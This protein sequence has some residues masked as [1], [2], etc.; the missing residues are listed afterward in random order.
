MNDPSNPAAT[1]G[2][3][4]A[5]V[6]PVVSSEMVKPMLQ[7]RFSTFVSRTHS[8]LQLM[9][10]SAVLSARAV[11]A[12]PSTNG[13]G[14]A[15]PFQSA[16]ILS[17][18][19]QVNL[20][21]GNLHV[22]VLT[23][24]FARGERTPQ[25]RL[26]LFHNSLAVQSV[27]DR[28][29]LGLG[30]GWSSSLG[31]CVDSATSSGAIVYLADG[32]ER[33]LTQQSTGHW[34]SEIG[35]ELEL[36]SSPSGWTLR[37]SQQWTWTYDA[38]GLVAQIR[39]AN[40]NVYAVQRQSG[41]ITAATDPCGQTLTFQSGAPGHVT[42]V[43]SPLGGAWSFAYD[44]QARVQSI[45]DPS[46]G[47]VSFSYDSKGRIASLTDSVGSLW[48][49][50]YFDAAPKL[51][52]V[53]SVI[54]P[55]GNKLWFD[56]TWGTNLETKVTDT[57]GAIWL[58]DHDLVD[59]PALVH[60]VDPLGHAWTYTA[61]AS[62]HI[63]TAHSP[64][65]RTW[66][67]SYDSNGNRLTS[68]DPI[69]HTGT[70]TYDALNNVT[71]IAYG[72][73]TAT[74]NYADA[75]HPTSP[76][77][78]VQPLSTGVSATTT[79][80]WFGANDGSPAGIWNGCLAS[81][82]DGAGAHTSF[83]YDST[84]AY[85]AIHEGPSAAAGR[86]ERRWDLPGHPHFIDHGVMP[87]APGAPTLPA[88]PT[89]IGGRL[90]VSC[91]GALTWF[92]AAATESWQFTVPLGTTAASTLTRSF[93]YDAFGRPTSYSVSTDEA[94][95]HATPPI[96]AAPVV[97]FTASNDDVGSAR[98]I[99]CHVPG[100]PD[101]TLNHAADACVAEWFVGSVG[102]PLVHD[103][104]T[105]DADGRVTRVARKDGTSTN[106]TYLD[107][108]RIDHIEHM[109]GTQSLLLLDYDYD[110]RDL[111]ITL[112]ETSSS[113]TVVT[114]W[115]YDFAARLLRE[116]RSVGGTVVTEQRFTYD[117]AGNRRSRSNYTGAQLDSV[118]TYHYDYDN[119]AVHGTHNNRVV[120]VERRASNRTL[121]TTLYVYY[122][123][124]FGHVSRLARTTAGST[125]ISSTA[126]QYADDGSPW[127][128]WD[129]TWTDTGTG[130]ANLVRSHALETR[131]VDGVGRI[132]RSLDPQTFA[133]QGETEWRFDLGPLSAEFHI[134][135]ADGTLTYVGL[136]MSGE[137]VDANGAV[138]DAMADLVGSTR[139]Y[140]SPS[141]TLAQVF[142][143][144]GERISAPT[145]LPDGGYCGTLGVRQAL[146]GNAFTSFGLVLA[147]H[148]WYSP[149]LGRFV[150][151]DP[152][153]EHGGL[154]VYG[155]TDGAPTQSVDPI[156][157]SPHGGTYR[158]PEPPYEGGWDDPMIPRLPPIKHRIPSFD[159]PEPQGPPPAIS[160][161]P[162]G[163]PLPP[164]LTG[165]TSQTPQEDV[166]GPPAPPRAARPGDPGFIGPL[167]VP[168]A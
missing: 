94:F 119:L 18:N 128:I 37:D 111:P 46:Y 153:G 68:T 74:I 159:R 164:W 39:D 32:T 61:D 25:H 38:S 20:A 110:S 140:F 9:V 85:V 34:R 148:R 136:D 160:P 66:T 45:A 129:E 36:S 120:S 146:D 73:Q 84:A 86:V 106:W 62:R 79:Y 139:L 72:G 48:Q 167:P 143:A 166:Y 96:P 15:A 42:S 56:Y 60:R 130:P 127:L 121:I 49:I 137:R 76:T 93:D 116:T 7:P 125:T 147:G 88:L 69:G 8:I 149:E 142:S 157:L 50:S 152:I 144:W 57:T 77:S 52:R 54:D 92:A 89:P 23:G 98:P 51:D 65:G 17:P 78:Y 71:S 117:S 134:A 53:M 5:H 63:L 154:N 44:A 55:K 161:Y 16:W 67:H 151:R 100:G 83:E 105:R 108:N 14:P 132:W 29:G 4:L 21:T 145:A 27:G 40:A 124:P 133:P 70:R 104:I 58:T 11:E 126:M 135:P 141:G 101:V 156:G 114:T 162:Q 59:P 2:G 13:A 6:S 91:D 24:R 80:T 47:I 138:S 118:D 150:M 131:Q 163:P 113:G 165:D 10:F 43:L 168:S 22:A 30:A 31:G 102:T 112:T 107:N 3:E 26:L 19:L 99:V 28:S 1:S 103:I 82:D 158:G 95:E 64:I 122:D 123:N 81:I 33:L 87:P 35:T 41:L 90:A 109:N 97:N 12:T 115:E 75:A 155:Y